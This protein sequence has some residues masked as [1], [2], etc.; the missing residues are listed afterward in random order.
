MSFNKSPQ[1][2]TD[3]DAV[4]SLRARPG[5]GLEPF[6][7][8][9]P[10]LE[11]VGEAVDADLQFGQ[12]HTDRTLSARFGP[13]PAGILEVMDNNPLVCAQHAYVPVGADALC[14]YALAPVCLAGLVTQP[15]VIMTSQRTSHELDDWLRH[16]HC[17][18]GAIVEV[19]DPRLETVIAVNVLV[20]VQLDHNFEILDAIY[21]ER[22][23]RSFFVR[24]QSGEWDTRLVAGSPYVAYRLA[25]TPGEGTSLLRV[26]VMADRGGK[27]GPT[28]LVQTLNVMCGFEESLGILY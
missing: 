21:A 20:A 10:F 3:P 12:G 17:P 28:Q 4:V 5:L 14:L 6:V 9:H 1:E 8:S 15:P 16:V 27:A 23:E 7:A 13:D 22:Y 25:V 26:Q 18:E 19:D 11:L 2:A 24:E